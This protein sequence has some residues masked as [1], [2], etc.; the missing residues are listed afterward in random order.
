MPLPKPL[1]TL[2]PELEQL[3]AEDPAALIKT[4]QELLPGNAEKRGQA[5]LLEGRLNRINKDFQI[6]IIRHDDFQL[7][8]SRIRKALLD[9]IGTLEERDFDAQTGHT[10]QPPVATVPK[11]VVVYDPA[12]EAHCK[13]LNK[14]LNVL[15]FTKKIRV[16]NVNETLGEGLVA[17]AQQEM[18]DAD[19]LL[20]LITVNFFNSP[21]WFEFV[22]NAMGEGRR[23]IPLRMEKA[24]FEGTG[25][26]KLKSLP[27]MNR[28]VSEFRNADDAYM[29]IVSELRKLL[30]GK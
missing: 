23:I 13:M 1:A 10:A 20:V 17:R 30:P 6:N 5:I 14:H 15:K 4:L 28:A 2:K 19:Y 12:D 25:L 7:E 11:F 18:A 29:D 9:L 24:D 21:E 22:Y 8:L 27:S 3:L 16:Y 26:E